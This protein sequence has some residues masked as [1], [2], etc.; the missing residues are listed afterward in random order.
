MSQREH[1]DVEFQVSS[2]EASKYVKKWSDAT[3][4][5]IAMSASRGG[6]E[7]VIDVLVHSRAGAKHWES[8]AGV[9]KYDSD[10]DASVFQRISIRAVDRGM[11][12]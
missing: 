7:A 8:D 5:A 3:A 11:I 2:G 12:P 6:E 10:P 4:T 1:K 9:E